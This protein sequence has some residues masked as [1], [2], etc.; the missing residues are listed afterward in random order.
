MHV[1]CDCVVTRADHLIVARTWAC[2]F[3]AHPVCCT[4]TCVFACMLL[5][6]FL[7]PD[8]CAR[9]EHWPA[10]PKTSKEM[11]KSF[12]SAVATRFDFTQP[13]ASPL[14]APE[15]TCKQTRPTHQLPVLRP[16]VKKFRG[17]SQPRS[18]RTVQSSSMRD[19]VSPLVLQLLPPHVLPAVC[20]RVRPPLRSSKGNISSDMQPMICYLMSRKM[21]HSNDTGVQLEHMA[22]NEVARLPALERLSPA[23]CL[24]CAG[25][26]VVRAAQ[27]GTR[28]ESEMVCCAAT[29]YP[30]IMRAPQHI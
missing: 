7:S 6:K 12:T 21:L 18:E 13:A 10:D 15:P 17:A 25:Q 26:D 19:C 4:L 5:T 22:Y 30:P 14:S 16:H 20:H 28:R 8:C 29:V 2:P 9:Q 1:Q 24:V 11:N 3:D 23:R 27:I